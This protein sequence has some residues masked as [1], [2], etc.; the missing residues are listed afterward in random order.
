MNALVR[1]TALCAAMLLSQCSGSRPPHVGRG[2]LAPC[3]RTPNCVSTAE[4]GDQHG[5]EPLHYA[6]SQDSAMARLVSVIA[7]M[8]RTRII[9]RSER[10]LYATFTSRIWRFVD[11]VEFVFPSDT[12]IIHFRSASRLGKSD[13]G[14]NRNRME[15]IRL[16]FRNLSDAASTQ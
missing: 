12:S 3:P 8:P 15:D 16:R 5:I 14:V 13:L 11:D 2:E 7:D 1:L 4:T 10:Y 6:G 9:A